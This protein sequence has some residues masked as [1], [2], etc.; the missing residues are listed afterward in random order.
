LLRITPSALA[1]SSLPPSRL[2]DAEADTDFSLADDI[3]S[4]LLDMSSSDII[5]F[6]LFFDVTFLSSL[7]SSFF[8]S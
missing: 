1:S 5:I 6:L 7:P 4:S 3:S 2:L 8:F